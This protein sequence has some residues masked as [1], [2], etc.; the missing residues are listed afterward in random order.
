MIGRS[1]GGKHCLNHVP[2]SR[3]AFHVFVSVV[4]DEKEAAQNATDACDVLGNG[5]G[6]FAS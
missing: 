1:H 2:R 6:G 3:R 5:Y 4:F